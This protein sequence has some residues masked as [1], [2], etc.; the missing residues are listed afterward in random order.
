MTDNSHLDNLDFGLGWDEQLT[1]DGQSSSHFLYTD[2]MMTSLNEPITMASRSVD[3]LTGSRTGTSSSGASSVLGTAFGD[4]SRGNGTS[5][6][7][8]IGTPQT[9]S[10]SPADF[11]S[12]NAVG[13]PAVLNQT[14][15]EVSRTTT[16]SPST[17]TTTNFE[18]SSYGSASLLTEATWLQKV[19]EINVRLFEH[20]SIIPAVHEPPELSQT[21]E[22]GVNLCGILLDN[23]DHQG[24]SGQYKDGQGSEFAIDQTF[25]LSRQLIDILNQV[26]PR[27]HQRASSFEQAVLSPSHS[28]SHSHTHTHSPHRQQSS[29]SSQSGSGSNP[30]APSDLPP[31][32]IDPGSG[33]LVLSCY[34]RV[35]DIYDKIFG[36]VRMCVAKTGTAD[37]FTQIRLPGLTIGSFSLQSSSALQV[38]LF[39]QLAEQLLDRLRSIVALM[40]STTLRGTKEEAGSGREDR[41]DG[42]CLSDVTDVTLQAIRTREAEMVKRM[43]S[44]R[45]MLQQS[46]IM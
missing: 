33:L 42:S 4:F 10:L 39:I 23:P 31:T 24:R 25:L 29:R 32:S 6:A 5:S 18:P 34:L 40:D 9:S 21:G 46:G 7:T 41:Q 26:Y 3:D 30:L 38:T 28:H 8:S 44:V 15:G 37:P 36:H 20:A 43:N 14:L 13:W 45:R 19:A 27:F 1:L 22:K 11:K 16:G 17:T 12:A 35:I 2:E